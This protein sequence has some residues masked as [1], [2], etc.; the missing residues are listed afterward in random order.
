MLNMIVCIPVWEEHPNLFL[1]LYAGAVCHTRVGYEDQNGP[2]PGLGLL[3]HTCGTVGAGSSC[4][5][6]VAG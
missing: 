1:H 3:P 2:D 5:I 4:K 6:I